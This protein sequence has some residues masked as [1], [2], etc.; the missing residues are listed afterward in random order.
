M[1]RRQ[2]A[3]RSEGDV[4]PALVSPE[5]RDARTSCT[6]TP[7]D[8]SG[9]NSRS[10]ETFSGVTMTHWLLFPARDLT[11]VIF[12]LNGSSDTVG[13]GDESARFLGLP[14]EYVEVEGHSYI[15]QLF[16]NSLLDNGA[17]GVVK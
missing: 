5:V 8:S 12:K 1:A 3:P 13:T 7:G 15:T 4:A 16:T 11:S 10:L 14:A 9:A 2:G 17:S 6:S